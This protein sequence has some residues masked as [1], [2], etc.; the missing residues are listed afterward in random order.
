VHQQSNVAVDERVVAAAI[1]T[2]GQALGCSTRATGGAALTPIAQTTVGQATV[3]QTAV[4]Q[5]ATAQAA[6]I[7]TVVAL[8]AVARTDVTKAVAHSVNVLTDARR[9]SS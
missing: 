8:A 4:A 5:A 7:P 2:R 9:H 1:H 6:I 3:A